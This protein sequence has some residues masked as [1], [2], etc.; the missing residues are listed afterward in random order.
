MQGIAAIGV[1][2]YKIF[3]GENTPRPPYFSKSAQPTPNFLKIVEN[4]SSHQNNQFR[5]VETSFEKFGTNAKG[6]PQ[7]TLG[8]A[9]GGPQVIY[10]K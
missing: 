3:M 9:K 4:H 10:G 6:G 8:L 2:K 1:E 7:G 5:L